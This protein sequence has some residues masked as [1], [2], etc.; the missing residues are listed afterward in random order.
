V[1]PVL[2]EASSHRKKPKSLARVA[3]AE[4]SSPEMQKRMP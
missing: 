1:R 4:L 3:D 2:E